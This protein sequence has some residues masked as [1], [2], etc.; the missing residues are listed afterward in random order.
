M[1]AEFLFCP[2]CATPLERSREGVHA[3]MICP[4]CGFIHYRNPA[5]A[6]GLLIVDGGRVLLVRRRFDP[7]KGLWTMPSGFIEYDEDVRAAA[8]REMLEETGLEVE[9]D[10]LCAAESC[11]DDPRGNALLLVFRARVTGGAMRAGDDAED[12]RF[13][14][15]GCLPPI[16]FEAHRKVLGELAKSATR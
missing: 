2:L 14:P 4:S 9:I 10:C 5:P 8:V 1:S 15:L 12:V 13:F 16:A 6:A 7:F 11:F 3:R